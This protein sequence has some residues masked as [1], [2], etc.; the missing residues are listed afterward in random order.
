MPTISQFFGIVI[1]MYFDDHSPP[2][3]HAVYAGREAQMSIESLELIE[4][5]LPQRALGLVREW[6]EIHRSEL[7]ENWNK[8]AAHESLS[9]IQ[10][11]E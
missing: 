11:L 9:A 10:P 6:G 8:A 5:T 2:H 3:F 7:R 4:G 1:R